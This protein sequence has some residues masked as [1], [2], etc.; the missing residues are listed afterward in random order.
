MNGILNLLFDKRRVLS[1]VFLVLLISKLIIWLI[2]EDLYD[3]LRL[4]SLNQLRIE[5]QL[6]SL[7][8]IKDKIK[9]HDSV[10][11]L[12]PQLHKHNSFSVSTSSM[13]QLKAGQL[14]GETKERVIDSLERSV[15]FSDHFLDS[16]SPSFNIAFRNTI[17]DELRSLNQKLLSKLLTQRHRLNAYIKFLNVL[18]SSIAIVLAL[19]L[20]LFIIGFLKR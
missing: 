11:D 4:V 16:L 19:S 14:S 2:N 12:W 1:F 3:D 20:I 5:Y 17:D 10:I 9:E 7:M 15:K 8:T 13:N 6:D 18:D